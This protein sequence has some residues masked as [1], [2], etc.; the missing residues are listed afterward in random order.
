M[1][2]RRFLLA[3][4]PASLLLS[5][6]GADHADRDALTDFE[7]VTV[8][9]PAGENCPA[10]GKRLEISSTDADT[11]TIYVCNGAPGAPGED[12]SAA[13]I[14]V[15]DA[16]DA[17][18]HGGV[19]VSVSGGSP[20]L[21]C[22]GPPGAPGE[23]GEAGQ[24][25]ESV[26]IVA[27]PPGENCVEGGYKLQVGDGPV[28]YLCQGEVGPKGDPGA[29]GE[30]GALSWHQLT[31]DRTAGP[32]SG[33]AANRQEDLTLSLLDSTIYRVGDIV[34]VINNGEGSVNIEPYPVHQRIHYAAGTLAAPSSFTPRGANNHWRG[35]ASSADG[36]KLVA[37]AYGGQI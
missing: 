36:R 1:L 16:G 37:V 30:K 23:G 31:S 2:N 32:N 35:L 7:V 21:I 8:D 13:D 29:Q 19:S 15:T 6:R 34:R 27:E 18:P 14:T 26:T 11:R 25:G 9:E 24:D 33:F 12:G 4:L 22:N 3:A 17:C 5:C 20:V 28:E 10:G